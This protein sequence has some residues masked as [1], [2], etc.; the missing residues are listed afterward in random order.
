MFSCL[1][2]RVCANT[3]DRFMS[4]ANTLVQVRVNDWARY[5]TLRYTTR[6]SALHHNPLSPRN[7]QLSSIHLNSP[8]FSR[9]GSPSG[10]QTSTPICAPAAVPRVVQRRLPSATGDPGRDL[11]ILPPTSILPIYFTLL[12]SLT[13]QSPSG[14]PSCP[15]PTLHQTQARHV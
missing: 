14:K 10:V 9:N 12:L 5:V 4:T 7:P 8:N 15:M 6:Q 2:V 11:G 3:M 1:R 13:T